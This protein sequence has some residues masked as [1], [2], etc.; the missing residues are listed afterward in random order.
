MYIPIKTIVFNSL[1][2]LKYFTPHIYAENV[3]EHIVSS[4]D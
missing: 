3:L 2:F 1:Q 4:N